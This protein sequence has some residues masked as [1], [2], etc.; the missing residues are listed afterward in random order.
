LTTKRRIK[1][2]IAVLKVKNGEIDLHAGMSEQ[3][4]NALAQLPQAQEFVKALQ[5]GS[6]QATS[7]LQGKNRGNQ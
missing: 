6:R 3:L 2:R 4:K 5:N 1:W 7:D